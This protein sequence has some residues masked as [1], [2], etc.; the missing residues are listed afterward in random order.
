MPKKDYCDY[1]DIEIDGAFYDFLA[2]IAYDEDIDDYAD[3]S[4][5]NQSSV[6][7]KARESSGTINW[8]VVRIPDDSTS[9]SPPN[10]NLFEFHTHFT[11]HND[12]DEEE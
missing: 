1:G 10:Q 8:R 4:K 2:D 12:Q 11:P 7:F 6:Y 3:L 9:D 5:I